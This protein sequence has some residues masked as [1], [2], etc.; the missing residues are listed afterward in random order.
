[1]VQVRYPR[2]GVV[3]SARSE[4]PER[5]HQRSNSLQHWRDARCCLSGRTPVRFISPPPALLPLWV[6]TDRLLLNA[7]ARLIREML[8]SDANFGVGKHVTAEVAGIG[9]VWTFVSKM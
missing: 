7:T 9:N 1:M 8:P 5:L 3:L 6:F 2:T 4:P